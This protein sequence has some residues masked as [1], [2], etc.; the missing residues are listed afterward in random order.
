M[1]APARSIEYTK[2]LDALSHSWMS[3]GDLIDIV[4]PQ[5]PPGQCLRAYVPRGKGIRQY[6]EDRKIE[7]GARAIIN[8]VLHTGM[9]ANLIVMRVGKSRQDRYFRKNFFDASDIDK[10]LGG[11]VVTVVAQTPEVTLTPLIISCPL[12]DLSSA[13][14]DFVVRATD[15]ETVLVEIDGLIEDQTIR[16]YFTASAADWISD[17][18]G[19]Q[20]NITRNG[21]INPRKA[22]QVRT[23]S[24]S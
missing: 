5:L 2:V 19:F 8:R 23:P 10:I 13:K 9:D 15:A 24:P 6:S 16:L 7:M 11:N 17:Q 1:N 18:L 21:R 20:S 22:L 3:V 4:S 12:V 14:K